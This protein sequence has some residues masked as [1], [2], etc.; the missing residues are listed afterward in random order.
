MSSVL[1]AAAQ[2]EVGKAAG[3]NS[4][5]REPGGVFGIAILVAVF[6]EAGGYAS[7]K[8]FSD[9]LA[10]AIAVSA[11]LSLVGAIVGLGLPGRPR[12]TRATGAGRRQQRVGAVKPDIGRQAAADRDRLR[13]GP[14]NAPVTDDQ[15]QRRAVARWLLL[16]LRLRARPRQRRRRHDGPL[17]PPRPVDEE[18][19]RSHE[20]GWGKCFD[21]L[22]RVLAE[23][24]AAG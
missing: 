2:A 15:Q 5:L 21:N 22:E 19:V 18:A 24:L 1:G 16:R 12:A 6:A 23:D 13:G 8:A 14:R 20:D 10:A 11:A 9:G 4:M 7:A 17:H 3:A